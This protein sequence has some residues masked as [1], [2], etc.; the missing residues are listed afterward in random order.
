MLFWLSEACVHAFATEGCSKFGYPRAC[1]VLSEGMDHFLWSLHV[2]CL[3]LMRLPRPPVM[4]LGA[5]VGAGGPGVLRERQGKK[6]KKCWHYFGVKIH[7]LLHIRLL[8]EGKCFIKQVQGFTVDISEY[9]NHVRNIRCGT[10][11]YSRP[12]CLLKISSKQV[13]DFL[14]CSTYCNVLIK[15][16]CM[17]PC[18]LMLPLWRK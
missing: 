12:L 5:P 1:Q 18:R 6:T 11:V 7:P 16:K 4:W 17:C 10:T 15:C 8:F 3:I 14:K 13:K 2:I 9:V